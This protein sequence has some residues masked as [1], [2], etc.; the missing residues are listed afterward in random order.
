ML[1]Q[2]DLVHKVAW[3]LDNW[4]LTMLILQLPL[5]EGGLGQAGLGALCSV[6]LD[7]TSQSPGTQNGRTEGVWTVQFTIW[8]VRRDTR[9]ACIY[10]CPLT[11][12]LG[13]DIIPL[14]HIQQASKNT[15]AAI[16][17]QPG[18]QERLCSGARQRQWHLSLGI[19]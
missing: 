2:L 10:M 5:Q 18:Q 13:I 3:G 19:L 15:K 17:I 16:P 9:E 8:N 4:H 11:L 14:H 7:M 6:G 1:A 12:R